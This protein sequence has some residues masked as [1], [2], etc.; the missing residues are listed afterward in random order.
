MILEQRTEI[1]NFKCG[2]SE[3]KFLPTGDIFEFVNGYYMINGFQGNCVDGSANN[4]YLRIYEGDAIV[5]CAPLLGIKSKSKLSKSENKLIF[6]GNAVG[7]DYKVTFVPTEKLWFW[8]IELSG[9]KTADLIYAQDIGVAMQGGVLTNELYMSQYLDHK[10]IEGDNGYAVCSRQNQSQGDTFPYLRQGALNTK[11]TF[12]STDATQFFGLEYKAGKPPKSLEGNLENRNYQF[13]LSY[14]AL[15][16]EK[17]NLAENNTPIV[18]YGLFKE[19]HELA[20]TEIEFD[21]EIKAA[22]DSI[23]WLNDGAVPCH[24][25]QLK[26]EFGEPFSSDCMTKCELDELFPTKTLEEFDKDGKLLSFFTE[27]YQHVVLKE[28]EVKTERPHGNIITTLLDDKEVSHGLITSTNYIYGLFNGQVVAGNTSMHKFISTPRGLL[29]ILKNTGQRIYVKIDGKYQILAMPA[30]YEMGINYSK[31]YYKIADDT[32]MVTSFA[33]SK[34]SDIVLRMSSKNGVKYDIIVT[35]QLVMGDC[36]FQNP[37]E[38]E[39]NGNVLCFKPVKENWQNSP[40]QD[41]HYNIILENEAQISDDK[42]FFEDNISRNGSLLTI[43]VDNTDRFMLTI[44]GRTE[45][46]EFALEKHCFKCEK[47]VYLDFYK[48]LCCNFK[49]TI[50]SDLQ[51]ELDRLN[52][53]IIWYSHNAMTHFAV[54]HGLEQPGGAAWGTRD[55]CQGPIEY[56]LVTGH[57]TLA[58]TVLINIFEHQF[59]QTKEWPQWFMFDKYNV[60]AGDCHGDVVFWPL[61]CIHDYII[62]TGDTSILSEQAA[63]RNIDDNSPTEQ[64]ATIMD[65]IKL[66][67]TTIEERFLHGTALISYAGGDWDDTLQPAN[68]ALADYLVSAWTMAL[69]YQSIKGVGEVIVNT[70]HVFADKLSEMAKNIKA[71]FN[72][73]LIKDGVIAGFAYCENM[74]EI[75]YMLHPADDQTGIH[76]RLLPLTR[77]I[78]SEMVDDSQSKLNVKLIN[79]HLKCPDGVRLMDRPARYEG[80]VCKFFQR[81]EQAANVGREISLQYVHAHIRYIEAMAKMGRSDDAWEGLLEINPVNLNKSVKNARLRQSN[82]YFSSSE[83]A[84]DTRYEYQNNFDMLSSGAVE[85]KGGWRIYSSGPGIY[86]NQLISNVLGIRFTEKTIEIDPVLPEK[87]DGLHFNYTCFGKDIEFVY[88]INGSGVT[89]ICIGDNEIPFEKLSN[90]YRIGGAIIDKQELLSKLSDNNKMVINIG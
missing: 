51:A 55:V 57:Y 28:K 18:F 15:Q 35:N 25:V 14:T 54:P 12:Y 46:C 10:V 20:V 74:D 71:D 82:A 56:F 77:S 3:F 21:D 61:K 86:I 45:A 11:I 33:S 88:N 26:S 60:Q 48:K 62:A 69:A 40:Y 2:D 70:D 64:K 68:K 38:F 53:S 16:T 7:I 17:I 83:G 1:F 87:L 41:L 81:A 84:F 9:D 65:H 39:Q 4:I 34:A 67:V 19:N 63:Y 42:I 72:K 79:E 49:L 32:L 52:A 37:V 59:L 66:A 50:G 80:G 85:V 36:E 58:R 43:K 89:K 76:F 27:E 29:N 31:W 44:Q 78:I 90:P 22:Y 8:N 6:S 47:Q 23:E 13:E 75:R 73:Y 30:L 5:G 24:E